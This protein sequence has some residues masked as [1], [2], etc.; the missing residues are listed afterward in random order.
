MAGCF[1]ESLAVPEALVLGN[2]INVGCL[3]MIPMKKECAVATRRAV[4][5]HIWDLTAFAFL[6]LG[7]MT[8]VLGCSQGAMN[9][10]SV[11][12]PSEPAAQAVSIVGQPVSLSVPIG[13]SAT[14]SVT[15]TGTGPFTYQWT[16]N[17]TS[18]SGATSS[19][20]TTSEVSAQENG[21]K[22]AVSVSNSVNSVMS[23]SATLTVGPRSPETGDLRFQ[24]VDA[25]SVSDQGTGNV[26]SLV[27]ADNSGGDFA[28]TT[29]SPLQLGDGNCDSGVA[30]DC[31][32]EIVFTNLPAGQSGLTTYYDGGDYSK[33]G[34][35]L[36]G[37]GSGIES[38][39]ASSNSVIT[40][41][42]LEPGNN[43]YA[44]A[45]IQ[46]SQSTSGSAFDMK[47]EV[48]SPNAVQNTVANDAAQSRVVTAVSFDA[49]GQANLLSYGW[50]GNTTTVYDT[51]V[52]CV[53]ATD[54][55]EAASELAN[56][57]YILTAFGGDTTNGFLLVGT[58]V[59]G[60][61]LPRSVLMFDQSTGSFPQTADLAG[62]AP[63]ARVEYVGANGSSGG[64]ILVYEK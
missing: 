43:A 55:E 8:L 1:R 58:K 6:T 52:V 50:Q 51:Q 42:D 14:F 36:T 13:E 17:G 27:F 15:V 49:N 60:D 24:Q 57:G 62:Y 31:V 44:V 56:E 48:V 61:T 45:W 12:T 59:H 28:N 25:P 46:A 21:E 30:Y 41:L 29:A 3:S 32:W 5:L 22:F 10:A 64:W 16:E 35:D 47:R 63:V 40:S 20:Y 39:L 54:I 37:G 2:R 38:T 53:G 34:S 23:T 18:I 4:P 11:S 9:M 26:T 19:S 33:F 7:L